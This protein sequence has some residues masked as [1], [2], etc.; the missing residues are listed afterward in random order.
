MNANVID[1][2]TNDDYSTLRVSLNFKKNEEK[3]INFSG[4][5]YTEILKQKKMHYI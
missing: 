1:E 2:N 3:K 4:T 5:D